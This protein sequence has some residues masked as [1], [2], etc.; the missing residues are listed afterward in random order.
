[1]STLDYAVV[2]SDVTRL[3]ILPLKISR[4][5]RLQTDYELRTLS[6]VNLNIAVCVLK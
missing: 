3:E 4:P 1:M 6:T 5:L 2:T